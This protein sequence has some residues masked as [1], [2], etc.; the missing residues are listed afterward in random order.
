M[1]PPASAAGRAPGRS[2]ARCRNVLISGAGQAGLILA[3]WLS[4]HGFSPTVVE[5][6]PAVRDGA[7]RSTFAA[8]RSTSPG[9]RRSWARCSRRG[10][11]LA[12]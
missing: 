6:A 9:E 1:S 2:R 4:R 3:Y 12:G 7:R 11:A 10:R 8:R 5:R